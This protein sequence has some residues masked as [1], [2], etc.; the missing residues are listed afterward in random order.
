MSRHDISHRRCLGLLKNDVLSS[1]ATENAPQYVAV[2]VADVPAPSVDGLSHS[3]VTVVSQPA[4]AA[5]HVDALGTVV[6]QPSPEAGDVRA[7]GRKASQNI[8]GVAN[9]AYRQPAMLLGHPLQPG[10]VHFGSLAVFEPPAVFGKTSV[11]GNL[12]NCGSQTLAPFSPQVAPESSGFSSAN[13]HR[14]FE[15][16]LQSHA[17]EFPG[18]QLLPHRK[19]I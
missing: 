7:S 5:G 18:G 3:P 13:Q 9:E 11:L 17:D 2:D 16:P 10:D 1:P 8:H 19:L 6:S 15:M 4:P 12:E 14:I